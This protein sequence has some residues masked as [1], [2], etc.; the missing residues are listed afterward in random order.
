[1]PQL[2]KGLIGK[3]VRVTLTQLNGIYLWDLLPRKYGLGSDVII[4]GRLPRR[5]IA[6]P[7][8]LVP[9]KDATPRNDSRNAVVTTV[10]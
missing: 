6:L 10:P 3:Y 8:R 7:Y 2:G 5:C 9:S 1:M 4:R